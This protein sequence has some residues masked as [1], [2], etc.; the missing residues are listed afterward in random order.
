MWC[1]IRGVY[2]RTP[3]HRAFCLATYRMSRSVFL[4]LGLWTVATLI[5]LAAWDLL[6]VDLALARWFGSAAGFAYRDHWLFSSVMHQGARRLAWT[7]QLALLL[8]IWWPVGVLRLLTR[9]ERVHLLVATLAIVFVIWAVKSASLTSCPWDL[10][11]FGG[12]ARYVSH[13][14]W[15]VPDGGRGECFP[16]GHASSAF[17]FLTGY[18]WLRD[19]AP[20][21][22]TWWLLVTLAA[23]FLIGLAQQVRGAHYMSHTLWAAWLCWVVAWLAYLA[24]EHRGAR[25]PFA[26][27]RERA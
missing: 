27:P 12:S 11:E 10:A 22:A 26:S 3:A 19:K 5:L 9:R 1:S 2:P 16:A 4:R 14:A 18:F 6:A 25:T 17:C 8:A 13:W 21:A 15:G 20:R 23:G 24:L 7:L